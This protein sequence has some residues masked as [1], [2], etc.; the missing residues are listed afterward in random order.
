MNKKTSQKIILWIISVAIVIAM[1][2]LIFG[3]K[4]KKV[5]YTF[6]PVSKGTLLRTISANGKYLSKDEANVSFRISGPLTNIKVDVGDKVKK[7][8]FLASVD[9][10]TLTEKLEQAKKAVTIQKKILAY[11]KNNDDLYNKNQR[12]AQ[13]AAVQQAEAAVDEISKQ[14]Q[15]A[16]INAPI[17]G[18][19]AEKNANIGEVVQAGRP[20][21]K[22]V[23]EDEMRIEARVPEVDIAGVRIGQKVGVKFDAYP[24]NQKFKATITEID[25][26]PITVQNV[27][28]YVVKMQVENPDAG[29]RYGMNC[30]I[31]DETNRKDNVLMIPK[32]V[33]EKDGDKKFVT[34]LADAKKKTVAKKEIQVGLEGDKGMVEI[35]SGL[36]E[37][38]QIVT[39]K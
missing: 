13:K 2:F 19:V 15:Y 35:I 33:V 28:Y 26:T 24:E 30:T 3:S 29:L 14:F 6:T 10:G 27:V 38:E 21:I 39:V 18:T 8:Q 37:G 31:Y 22:I 34:I 9:V 16:N 20:V 1:G 4:N 36:R 11:E 7:G 17:S 32:G 12:S 25:P 23:R 5:D